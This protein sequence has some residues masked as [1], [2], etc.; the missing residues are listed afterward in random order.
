MNSNFKTYILKAT[1]ASDCK[2]LEVIKSLWSGYGEI[3]RYSLEGS[4]Y[5]TAVVKH[6][7]LRAE[8]KHPRGWDTDISHQ[9]KV[10]SYE[11]ETYWYEYWSAKCSADCKVPKY[12]GGYAEKEQQW[13]ILEDLDIDYPLRKQE[14]TLMEVRACLKWLAHFHGRFMNFEPTG[15]WEVGTYWHLATRPDE[16]ELIEHKQLKD[17]ASR[18]DEV[19]NKANYQTIVHGDAKLANFCFSEDGKVAAVDFQYVGGG[20]GMKDVAYFLGSCMSGD[21]CEMYEK[22][23]LDCYFR[24]LRIAVSPS[25]DFDALEQEWKGL[26][27][28]ACTD[29]MRFLL[30]WMPTHQ[31]INDYNLKMVK[32]VLSKL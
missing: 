31:K 6:I 3:V 18:I 32:E 10:K 7:D 2:E 4:A 9:R 1:T 19:L 15:L 20:C 16:W 17:A 30:G 24:E 21:E 14:L 26:Y 22:E 8:G 5:V 23:L 27:R 13:I 25:I 11:V 28:V 12:L 29:F